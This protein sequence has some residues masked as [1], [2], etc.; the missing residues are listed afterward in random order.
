MHG[1]HIL[2]FKLHVHGRIQFYQKEFYQ[3]TAAI[4]YILNYMCTA[5][6]NF[7]KD[8]MRPYSCRLCTL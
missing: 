2:Y 1:R 8:R 4:S 6:Y 5:A 7:I 3:C